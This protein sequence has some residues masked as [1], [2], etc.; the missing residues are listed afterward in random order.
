MFDLTW[1]QTVCHSDS[2]PVR[3]FFKKSADDNKACSYPVWKE[4]KKPMYGAYLL[5]F[6]CLGQEIKKNPF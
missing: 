3:I 1:I 6:I 4:E 5:K 2:A